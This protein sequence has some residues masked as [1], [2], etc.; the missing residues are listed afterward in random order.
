MRH[1]TLSFVRFAAIICLLAITAQSRAAS[2]YSL[3][4]GFA[5][6][7]T[8]GAGPQ[9]NSTLATDGTSF[10]GVTLSGGTVTNKGVIFKM[11]LTGSGY[12]LLHSFNGLT[13]TEF[14][15]GGHGNTNDGVNPSGTPLLIGSTLYG[16]TQL[17]GTNGL[18]TVYKINTYG[19]GFQLLH[20]FGVNTLAGDGDRP[21]CTLVTDGTNLFGMASSGSGNFNDLGTVFC[22]DTNGGNYRTLHIFDTTPNN[23]NSPQGSLTVSGG[24]LYGMTWM[25]G[26][27]NSGVIFA[28]NTDGTGFHLLHTFTGVA[29]D[30]ELPYGSLILSNTTLY[31]M[32]SSGG[33]NNVG[34]V[35]S[36]DTS[37]SG[38]QILHSFS[39][40]NA[41]RPVGDLTFF[42]SALYGMTQNGGSNGLGFG[43]IFQ[44]DPNGGNFQIL[45]TF[46]FSNPGNLTDG[47]MPFGSLMAM[48]SQ[49]YGMTI[50]GGSSKNSG[51]V[52]SFN[53]PASGGGGPVTALRVTIQPAAA[54]K[55]G[56][57]WQVNGNGPFFNSGALA[58]GLTGGA[59]VVIYTAVAGFITP[60]PLIIDL[61][62][63]IT[64][65]VTATYGV[66][67]TAK[68]TLKVIAPTSKT[69]ATSNLFTASG[70]ASDNV[71]LALVYYQLNGGAWAEASSG[72]SFTNWTAPNLNLNPGPNVISFYAKDL[73]GNLSATNTVTFTYT[74]YVP[75]LVRINI[76]GSGIVSPSLDG[77]TFPIGGKA[78]K[79]SAKAAK[80]FAFVNWTGSTNSSSPKISFVAESN[81]VFT[82][83]FKDIARPTDVILAPTKGH[84]FSNGVASGRAMDNVGVAQVYYRLNSGAWTTANSSDGTNW[85]TADLS[86]QLLSGPNTISTYAV[87]AAGNA[88]L[89]NTI[90]FSYEVS[91]AVDWAPDSLNGSTASVTPNNGSAEVVGFDVSTFSQT[92]EANDGNPDDYG[93]GLYEYAKTD[94]NMAQLSLVFN[95][96]P[97]N[98]ST[99]GPITL[100][101]TNHYTGY[102]TNDSGETGGINIVLNPAVIPTSLSGKTL[103]GMSNKNGH[104]TKVKFS[105]ATAFSLT[106]NSGPSSG[107]YTFTRL[108]PISGMVVVSFTDPADAGRTSY[109]QLT[110]F[111]AKTGMFFVMSFDNLGVLEDTDAG[112]FSM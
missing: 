21:Q 101:F 91:A 65:S 3:L 14:L 88:S 7:P 57:Q 13:F 107:T 42:N 74:V 84:V 93:G 82:A 27:L 63:G 6:R 71:G 20:S 72:N 39:T 70:T 83:N 69:V 35:F 86:G 15:L 8:D 2:P 61:T 34:T 100:V 46:F 38:F 48:G 99:V 81:L 56:A 9:Y 37:G 55:A 1:T 52:F 22:L 67:D 50:S 95:A 110:F 5:G 41:W 43:T 40:A 89:T 10:Y 12:Q 104:T 112:T 68:P 58:S 97:G 102:F 64:N 105:S 36:I 106:S 51:A 80:G 75:V 98:S 109:L 19:S 4:H 76:P 17:G 18:G 79:L 90:A 103:T 49:L 53:P 111:T 44:I 24:M 78:I 73:S 29:T 94:T 33:A 47:S 30:G 11:S 16:I 28:M 54:A 77:K 62:A 60:A 45:H 92:G 23:G 108:S 66:A 26:A 31:G 85:Q 25:G 87:D 32:T 59:H 96:V